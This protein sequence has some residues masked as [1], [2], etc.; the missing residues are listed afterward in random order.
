MPLGIE[1]GLGLGEFVFDGD[2]AAPRKK[3]KKA[4]PHP[5]WPMYCGQ[6]AEWIKK[7]LGTEVNLGPGDVVLDVVASPPKRGT[8]VCVLRLLWLQS[9][10]TRLWFLSVFIRSLFLVT[11]ESH[12]FRELLFWSI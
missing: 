8:T 9:C 6:T 11:T 3:N 2:P 1:V 12:I 10:V 7:P 4:Q 5:I